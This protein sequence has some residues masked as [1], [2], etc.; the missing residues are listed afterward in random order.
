MKSTPI[1]QNYPTFFKSIRHLNVHGK[2]V[3]LID[4]KVLLE[5]CRKQNRNAQKTLYD[6]HFKKM[7]PICLRYLK[8]E[9]DAL[10]VLNTAFLKV[11]A[12]INQ[13]KSEGSLEAWIKRIV[14]N[15]SI[16][17][18][19]SSK[20][21]KA[22]FIHTNE[23]HL[24]GEP[25]EE[26]DAITHMF[27]AALD[28]SKEEIFEMVAELPPATRIVFNLYVID[29]FTHRQI[30]GNLKISEGTSKWHLSN[31][32]KILKEKINHVVAVKNKNLNHGEEAKWH[33]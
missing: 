28:F 2:I 11:F 4:E 16:D 27:D 22:N 12:K 31:A 5:Q 19:R 7:M 24:Y 9:E 14:I 18:V 15:S 8:S 10:E 26:D 20:S 32:R 6:T 23:F 25:G 29:E 13:F 33:R 1:L 21:Y 17:Y 30:A 3:S